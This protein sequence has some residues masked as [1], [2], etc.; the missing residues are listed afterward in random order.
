MTK[1]IASCYNLY[2]AELIKNRSVVSEKFFKYICA[3]NINE[4]L[5]IAERLA[6]DEFIVLSIIDEAITPYFLIETSN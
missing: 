3:K 4:A 5:D 6:R 2:K 1:Q